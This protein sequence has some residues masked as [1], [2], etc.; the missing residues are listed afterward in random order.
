MTKLNSETRVILI[1]GTSHVGKS[2]LGRSLADKLDWDYVSTDSL[3]KHPGRPWIN[4]NTK[5]IRKYVAKHY[6]SLSVEALLSDVL[7][8]YQQNILPQV[9]TLVKDCICDR[10]SKSL[11]IEGSALYPR[12]VE[13]LIDTKNVRGIWL[14]ASDRIVQNRIYKASNFYN[15][16]QEEKYLIQKF[17]ERTL[18]YDRR[19][20][21]D[22]KSLELVQIDVEFPTSK[23]L[24]KKCLEQIECDRAIGN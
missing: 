21:E 12:F 4:E 18:I 17:L 2:T 10:S 9:E 7:L 16:T 1:G 24:I 15:V 23:E 13:Y 6:K 5:V 20:R 19:M 22:I 3:G 11:L 14:T 8:H